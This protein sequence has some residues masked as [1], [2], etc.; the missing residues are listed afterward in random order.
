MCTTV[1][2]NRRGANIKMKSNTEKVA[3]KNN[4]LTV[5]YDVNIPTSRYLLEYTS[6]DEN[7]PEL[8]TPSS[9]TVVDIVEDSW[10]ANINK[11][12]KIDYLLAVA[13]GTIAAAVDIF[14]TGEFSLVEGRQWGNDTINKFVK[15]MAKWNG[16]KGDDLS[17]A[18]KFMEKMFPLAADKNTPTFGG[19][20]Q[21][22]L[23][24][25]SHHF[26]LG[27][28]MCSI[29]TQFTKKVIGTDPDGKLIIED[30]KD[31]KLIGKN[32]TEKILFG[33]VYWFFH[34]VSD[35]AGSNATA[36]NGTGIPGPIVSLIKELS[37]LPVFRN[38]QIGDI[39][40]HTWVSKLFNGTLLGKRD[41]AGKL[42]EPMK[43]DLRTEIGVLHEIGK[44]VVPVL[45]NESLVRSFYFIRRLSNE[46]KRE[47]IKS[48]NDFKKINVEK[49]LPF[50]NRT[51]KRM[52]TV[53]SGTLVALD[54]ADAAV[55]AGM[56]PTNF[57]VVFAVR[58]NVVG[59]GRFIVAC[60]ADSEYIAEDIREAKKNRDEQLAKEQEFE[61]SIVD[62]NCFSLDF[63]EM[64]I[65]Y[66]LENLIVSNDISITKN[67]ND[68]DLKGKWQRKWQE[69]LITILSSDNI[70]LENFFLNETEIQKYLGT[71]SNEMAQYLIVLEAMLFEPYFAIFEDDN[72]KKLKKLK[73]KSKYL[74]EN[75]TQLQDLISAKEIEKIKKVYR[76]SLSKIAGA[77]KGMIIG[78]IGTAAVMIA[79]AALAFTFAPVIAV[80]LVGNGA[81][82]LSGAALISHCLAVLGG[83]TLAAGGLGMAGGTAVITG[84]G[85]LLGMVSG[86]GMSAATVYLLSQEGYVLSECSRLLTY[87]KVVLK[88]R[89]H[90]EKSIIDIY[91]K[92]ESQI[93]T[94][95][96]SITE[97]ENNLQSED[98]K[99]QK[100]NKNKIKVAKNSLKYLE[101][102]LSELQKLVKDSK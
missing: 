75:Y 80:A 90:D 84:G 100:E 29:F 23:R 102:C 64:R 44:Q 34:M 50:N 93:D 92:L 28:L 30:V 8:I 89:L 56:N 79:S 17:G 37:S 82:G 85:A 12:D 20:L 55:R 4:E 1:N 40:F 3:I 53:S 10:D 70:T 9:E 51:I 62:L 87:C 77:D 48:F 16:Y 91:T 33:T 45:I 31:D 86:T 65:L 39:E 101:N 43:F 60:K 6:G 2:S 13:S 22:H 38:K 14:Y 95:K 73:N 11:A 68:A 21:H 94:I 88:E 71:N 5:T 76:K 66:S 59:V 42:L 41:E 58:I 25:F 52:V 27:G 26:S 61:K 46:L 67:K 72:D 97:F 18:I 24:D 19:G 35:M 15:R 83:G 98:K 96:N 49:I 81:A 74:L 78:A 36:G 54:A 63:E 69:R 32:N 47:E 7:S 99:E 57:F